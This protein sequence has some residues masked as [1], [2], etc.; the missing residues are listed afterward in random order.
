MFLLV[1]FTMVVQ[2]VTAAKTILGSEFEVVLVAGF[3]RVSFGVL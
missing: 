1:L 3:F 2:L